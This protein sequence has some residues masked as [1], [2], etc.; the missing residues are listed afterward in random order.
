M[1]IA[2]KILMGAAGAGSKSTY[3]DDVFSTYLY[4]GTGSSTTISN[5]LDLSGEGG[6]TWIKNRTN[7]NKD[8]VITD[9]A[10][11]AGNA[12]FSNSTSINNPDANKLA[13]FTSTGFGVGT[14]SYVNGGG[15]KMSSWSFRKQKGF[16][17]IVTYTGN[18]SV[19]TISHN[20]G[21]VPGCIMI[22]CTTH[23]EGWCV[24]HRGASNTPQNVALFLNQSDGA[25]SSISHWNNTAPTSTNFTLKNSG[26][27]NDNGKDYVAYIFA[28]GASDEPGAARSVA[29]AG[30]GNNQSGNDYLS[31]ASSS[32]VAYGTGDFT[33]EAWLKP[34]NSA[35]DQVFL[36]HG[37]DNPMLGIL[38]G[39]WQYYNSTVNFKYAGTPCRGDWTHFAVSRSSGTTRFFINGQ[40][41]NSWSDSHNY[42]AQ[43]TSIGAY[44]TGTYGWNGGISNVR[45]VKGTAVYTSSFKP[46]TTGLTDITNTKLLCCNK[47]TV[48]GS[49]VTFGTITSNGSPQSST[50]TP[51]DDPAGFKFGE[52]GDQNIIKCGAYVGDGG[53]GNTEINLGFEPQWILVKTPDAGDDWVLLDSMRG[54]ATHDNEANDAGLNPNTAGVESTQGYLDLTSTGFKTTLYT[55][56]NVSGRKYV[57]MAIRRPDSYVGKPVE[58]GTDVFAIATGRSDNVKPTFTT[59][60][61]VDFNLYRPV[62]TSSWVTNTRLLGK[63]I[64]Y[65]DSSGSEQSTS[66]YEFD[67]NTGM[68]NWTGDQSVYKSWLW[69]RHS[70]FDVVAFK[71]TAD[72]PGPTYAHGLGKTPELKIIKR[73]NASNTGWIGTGTVISQAKAGNLTSAKDY[74]FYWD[75]QAAVSS[76]SNY[77]SGNDT[78]THFTVR[79]GN[80]E[81]G[82]SADPY[83]CLLFA[84]VDGISKVGYYT[85]NGASGQTITT[86]FQPRF[87]IIKNI[88]QGSKSWMVLDTVRGWAAGND[89]YL[90]LNDSAAQASHDFGNPTSTGFYLHGGGSTY[91]GSSTNYIYYAH[92]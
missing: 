23:D 78:S 53:T 28:G 70:G 9:T 56:L 15:D 74:Y 38:N 6:M 10:R 62:T 66:N 27:S 2:R 32:D 64:L 35:A 79:H 26:R 52:E 8:H 37:S 19:R 60:F 77:W 68:G 16:F 48:T 40:E 7:S 71:G 3:I 84:S 17:D 89:N 21:S 73:R 87:I 58:A 18:G 75:T 30:T 90:Q 55:N 5:G 31:L 92:A 29:F 45:I 33:I 54:I 59:G 63:K 81:G 80:G 72:N 46:S 67:H 85:G 91:N 86:G 36:N 11:G 82:G 42:G 65:T 39:K 61:P 88:D 41:R 4:E 50:T 20:L 83:L 22:K 34:D 49:T 25:N 43:V 13:S 47:N 1:S 51:F 69:K 76:S 12:I 57:F 24:Y 14:D 44:A